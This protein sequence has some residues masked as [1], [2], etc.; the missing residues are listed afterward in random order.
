MKHHATF[1]SC[2]I[3]VCLSLAFS[4]GKLAEASDSPARPNILLILADDVGIDAIECYGGTSYKTPHL[5]ALAETGAQFQHCHS[6]PVCHPTRITLMTGRYPGRLGRPGWGTF[7][8]REEKE[9]LAHVL[10][11]A[12]Y[13]TAVAGK[14]QLTLLKKDPKHPRKLG[15]DEWCLF[16]WHE[17]PRYYQPL[18]WQNGKIRDD[19]KDR[20]GPDV[21]CEFLIDFMERNKDRPFLA[22]YP[23]ALCHAVT[24]DLKKPVPYAPGK[25]HYDTFAEMVEA[26]DARVG[27]LTAALD[28]LGLREKTLILFVGDNGSPRGSIIRAE[29]GKYIQDPVVSMMGDRRVPGGKGTLKDT[30][31]NVPLIANWKGTIP[32]GTV[33]DDLVDM[34]D[35][36]PTLAELA[37][38]EPPEGVAL[39]GK[40]FAPQL[41]GSED[42]HRDWIY[43]ER[44]GV[45]WVRSQRWKLYSDGHLF[46]MVNDPLEKSPIK[47]GKDSEESAAARGRLEPAMD[48]V[49]KQ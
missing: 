37:G 41:G 42:R 31:T 36:L 19:V 11:K 43:S 27:R 16:G 39:D 1:L 48:A 2:C 38:A 4:S 8:R 17:G 18:L 26:M 14:W 21:Y 40:S 46:D 15:F 23:M 9:T 44:K 33:R 20:Y 10:K 32:G 6:M 7:P 45:C 28:R 29:N 47:A 24:D 12:G 5:N 34:S 22:Y 13:A 35:F 3:A 49:T 25:D 30:G